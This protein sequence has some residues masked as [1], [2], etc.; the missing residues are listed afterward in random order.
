MYI[1]VIATL[2]LMVEKCHTGLDFHTSGLCKEKHSCQL[3][4]TNSAKGALLDLVPF[5]GTF[6]FSITGPWLG[7]LSCTGLSVSAKEEAKFR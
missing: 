4:C 3:T 5:I 6:K 1:T 2:T 7:A